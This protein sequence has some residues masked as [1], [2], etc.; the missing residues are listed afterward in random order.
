MTIGQHSS[1]P[2]ARF[3]DRAYAVWKS[4]WDG[5]GRL[6]G[7]QVERW[8]RAERMILAKERAAERTVVPRR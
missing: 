3:I 8:R 4:F 1:G 7:K 2:Q 5:D 6:Y